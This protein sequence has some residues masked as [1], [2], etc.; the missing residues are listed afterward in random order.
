MLRRRRADPVVR[1]CRRRHNHH[2][3]SVADGGATGS[4]GAITGERGGV[5]SIGKVTGA[6]DL[7]DSIS[8]QGNGNGGQLGGAITIGTTQAPSSLALSGAIT[9]VANGSSGAG[10]GGNISL[11]SSGLITVG[12]NV[13]SGETSTATGNSGT[14]TINSTGGDV[15]VSGNVSSNH[16][17]PGRQ[18]PL[19]SITTMRPIRILNLWSAIP[20]AD[21][22]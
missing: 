19:P 20:P 6:T 4:G 18:V 11:K 10:H 16:S 12:G 17:A 21:L 3:W 22:S 14:I 1:H 9:S 13:A 8:S 2:R 15:Q 5:A 7:N